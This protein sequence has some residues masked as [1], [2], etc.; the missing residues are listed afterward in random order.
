MAL[1]TGAFFGIYGRMT[2]LIKAKGMPYEAAREMALR[3]FTTRLHQCPG[4]L[5]F[6]PWDDAYAL[7]SSG[8]ASIEADIKSRSEAGPE[9][10]TGRPRSH[11]DAPSGPRGSSRRRVG[12]RR[13]APG[14]R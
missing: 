8:L 7:L 13:R 2:F 1:S 14:G 3:E 4:A 12:F 5:D 10:T 9:G 11:P 6:V